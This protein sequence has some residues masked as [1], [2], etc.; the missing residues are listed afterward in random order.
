MHTASTTPPALRLS[1][2]FNITAAFH[3]WLSLGQGHV[4]DQPALGAEWYLSVLAVARSHLANSADIAQ[5]LRLRGSQQMAAPS[6]Q[7]PG[8]CLVCRYYEHN[9]KCSLLEQ[10]RGECLFL[11]A[12]ECLKAD[13]AVYRKSARTAA[14]T[15]VQHVATESV[16]KGHLTIIHGLRACVMTLKLIS[17]MSNVTAMVDVSM[18]L[19]HTLDIIGKQL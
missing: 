19:W 13:M 3:V 15:P 12:V 14:A 17:L 9:S 1:A 16:S 10:N 11:C 6:L 4:N 8:R 5:M 2:T 18:A 7:F